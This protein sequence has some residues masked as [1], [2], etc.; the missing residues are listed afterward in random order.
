[1]EAIIVL[2]LIIAGIAWLVL[3][4]ITL[5]KVSGIAWEIQEKEKRNE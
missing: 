3:P 5:A 4:F 1:M 2:V